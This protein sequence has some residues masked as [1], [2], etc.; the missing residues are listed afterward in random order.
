[1]NRRNFFKL[2]GTYTGGMLL[3][4]DFLHA[5]AQ[6]EQLKPGDNSLVF[7]QLYGGNDGLNTY[8]P[9]T[10]ELYYKYRP[11][12]AIA[13]DK[14]IGADKGMAFHPALKGLAN[15]QQEGNL[16]VIQNVGYPEPSRSHFR[17][18]EIWETA[19]DADKYLTNGWLGRFLDLQCKGH[20][21]LAGLNV[22]MVDN[23]SLKGMEPNSITTR[24][25]N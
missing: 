1:M 20:Q 22:D 16:S 23:L 21:P 9:Y 11:N 12:I 13:R 15:I 18:R 5:F 25:S 17:S 19:S 7:I 4:P 2:T 14:V 6:Q 10:N 3:L 8:I 24:E